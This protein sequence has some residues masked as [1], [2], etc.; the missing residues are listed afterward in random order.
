MNLFYRKYGVG[1]PLLILHGL[2]GS[3]DNWFSI[4]KVLEKYF[5]VYLIDLRNHGQSPHS[6]VHDYNT[7]SADIE[8][9]LEQQSLKKIFLLGHSM[10]GK[11]SIKFTKNNPDLVKKLIIV[12]ISPFTYENDSESL[13]IINSHLKILKA[14]SD[15]N[16]EKYNSREEVDLQL[17][18]SI[19]DNK[20]R[21]FL[22][23]N[24]KRNSDNIFYWT[25]NINSIKRNIYEILLD[26]SLIEN[27]EITV[28]TL[29]IKGENS[30][31]IPVEHFDKI[32]TIFINSEIVTI[33]N[34]GHWVHA[35]NQKDFIE[36]VYEFLK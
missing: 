21:Q 29:F 15:L 3:S 9:F 6:D 36:C 20:L 28:P 23:K 34:S 1:E 24:L 26:G 8:E 25:F 16:V 33:K 4:A 14:L 10:G 22:L 27:S 13:D 5:T 12:D 32:K 35:E 31:Y 18:K 30:E 17:L 19:K 2:Y 11:I 7:M